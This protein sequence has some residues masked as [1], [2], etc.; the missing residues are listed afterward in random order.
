VLVSK[1]AGV[2]FGPRWVW[3]TS[4][5]DGADHVVA[6]P[7]MAAGLAAGQGLFLASCGMG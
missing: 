6:D 3:V 7:A 4:T 5:V 2:V 1:R